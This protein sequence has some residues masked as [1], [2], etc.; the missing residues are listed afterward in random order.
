MHGRTS[1]AWRTSVQMPCAVACWKQ[2]KQGEAILMGS[3]RK[4]EEALNFE[5]E[6]EE[7]F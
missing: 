2:G 6:P 3:R 5:G 7:R 1:R 4:Q